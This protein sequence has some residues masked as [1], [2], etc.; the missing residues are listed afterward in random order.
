MS[1]QQGRARASQGTDTPDVDPNDPR[2]FHHVDEADYGTWLEDILGPGFEQTTLPLPADSAGESVMTI[3]RHVPSTDPH[4]QAPAP[5]PRFAVIQMHGW[6]DYFYQA[7]TARAVSAAGGAFYAM[8][9]RRYGRS[10]RAGQPFGYAS[11][12]DC[13]DAELEACIAR[14]ADDGLGSLPLFLCAHSTG[15][16]IA[17]L[18]ANRHPGVLAGLVLNSP[19]LELQGSA[20]MRVLTGSVAKAAARISPMFRVFRTDTGNYQKVLTAW[21]EGE[22]LLGART[23]A[24]EKAG[25]SH[26]RL[27]GEEIAPASPDFEGERAPNPYAPEGTDDQFWTTGWHPDPRFRM[28]PSWESRISW[29]SAIVAGHARVAGGLGIDCPILVM[30][31]ARHSEAGSWCEEITRTDCILDLPK[32]WQRTGQLGRRVEL[33]KL[34]NAIHDVFF[35]RREVREQAFAEMFGFVERTLGARG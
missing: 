2:R 26:L 16:L 5:A 27:P 10:L 13:Y 21:R 18:W 33:V 28:F 30:T 12:L 11:S 15:G 35:S 19:W 17:S 29:M 23:K 20:H 6:N 32:V 24:E 4:M 8:D 31:S 3:V 22:P 7:H 14:I 9:L 1:T 25:V 34:E